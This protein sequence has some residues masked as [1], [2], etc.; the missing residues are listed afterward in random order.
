MTDPAF[1]VIIGALNNIPD[2]N[3]TSMFNLKVMAM[4]TKQ[5]NEDN[6]EIPTKK[7]R[8]DNKS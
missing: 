8:L 5:L 4:R 7:A 3:P 1:V 6:N 2:T